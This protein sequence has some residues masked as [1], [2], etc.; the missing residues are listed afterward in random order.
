MS[1]YLYL[2]H[3]AASPKKFFGFSFSVFNDQQASI[4]VTRVIRDDPQKVLDNKKTV[5]QRDFV[6]T[7][8]DWRLYGHLI[9]A[10][11][12]MVM[13][14]PMN[15]YAPSMIKSL[16]FSGLQANGLNSV[17]SVC[18]LVWSVSLAYNSDRQRE[19]GLHIATGYLWG[20]IGLFW[21]ALAPTNAGK[22][23]LYGESLP[24]VLQDGAVSDSPKVVLYGPRWAWVRHKLSTQLGSQQRC[25]TTSDL[26]L[27]R[28]ML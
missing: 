12:S 15:T 4:L 28:L 23:V 18:A 21:L 5:K 19:R 8:T 11:L 27:W 14:S 6:G 2:P 7:F 16:G 10:F 24:C 25:T 20:A 13:I 1:A 26:S 17:G 3:N 9:A 22:W